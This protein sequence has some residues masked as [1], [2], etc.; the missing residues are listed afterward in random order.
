MGPV[1][2]E[3]EVDAPRERV[4][5]LIADLARRPSFTDH[6]ASDLHL[7]RI[8]S[9]GVGAGA[10]FRLRLAP[11]RW[12]DTAIAVAEPPHRVVEHGRGGR[13]NRIPSTTVWEVLGGSGSLTLVRVTHWTETSNPLD[14][15][16]DVLTMAATRQERAWRRA[17]QRL[18]ELLE[19]SEPAPPP[20]AV[21]G[22][23]PHAT[24][25]P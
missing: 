1:G 3:L 20:L 9:T 5:A 15:A 16:L 10:R 23:N 4:F 25:I 21:A 13:G 24:G 17:L 6:L 7:T 8:D 2:A 12:M 11:R 14:R 18:R 19:S 22:G